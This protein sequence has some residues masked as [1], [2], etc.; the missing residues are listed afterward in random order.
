M[1]QAKIWT[2]TIILMQTS[3]VSLGTF[4]N[5]QNTHRKSTCPGH[6]IHQSTENPQ[7]I[8]ASSWLHPQ[9]HLKSNH[10][11][12]GNHKNPQK[13]HRI[14]NLNPWHWEL[15]LTN[16]NATSEILYK[17]FQQN[18]EFKKST[19]LLKKLWLIYFVHQTIL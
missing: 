4:T 8:Y 15:W 19:Q 17:S 13:I 18:F 5:P 2:F 16:V 9:F 11:V 1:K 3:L 14:L 6:A 10:S 12:D 7:K